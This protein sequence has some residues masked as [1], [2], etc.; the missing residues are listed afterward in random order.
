MK[1]PK[2]CHMFGSATGGY[3]QK[4]HMFE[5]AAG[6]TM[7]TS[8]NVTGSGLQPV[9]PVDMIKNVIGQML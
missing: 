8:K 3:D 5:S 6:T 2:K 9:Q 4:C 1:M 7:E